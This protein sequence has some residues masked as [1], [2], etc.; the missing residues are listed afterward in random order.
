M[1]WSRRIKLGHSPYPMPSGQGDLARA[2]PR[3]HPGW[4]SRGLE[5]RGWQLE[6]QKDEKAR[7]NELKSL[8]HLINSIL[9]REAMTFLQSTQGNWLF[10]TH[11]VHFFMGELV[12]SS[13]LVPEEVCPSFAQW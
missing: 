11:R 12:P 13:P 3:S 1:T 7:E 6:R 5:K 2:R 8:K 4:K 9:A 10:R